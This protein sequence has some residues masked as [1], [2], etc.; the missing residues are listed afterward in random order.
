MKFITL[1]FAALIFTL[2]ACQKS[3]DEGKDGGKYILRDPKAGEGFILFT[4]KPLYDKLAIAG[5]SEKGKNFVIES[6]KI[7]GDYLHVKVSYA[8]G[9][10]T[11]L[12]DVVW[13]GMVMESYP[14]QIHLVLKLNPGECTD[15]QA[16]VTKELSI[17]VKDYVGDFATAN[18][19]IFSVLNASTK[20][21]TKNQAI[22]N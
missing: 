21:T 1:M 15:K 18:P 10:S 17:H 11:D 22:Q 5:T 6:V 14:Y 2:P 13:D 4:E 20:T 8:E 7:E 12:F 9:C 19:T 3:E 16:Q